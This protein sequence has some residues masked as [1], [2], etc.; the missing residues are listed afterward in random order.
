LLSHYE[1]DLTLV[2]VIVMYGLFAHF[3]LLPSAESLQEF[4]SM[5]N[6]KGGNIMVLGAMSMIFFGTAMRFT[7]WCI[8]QM[9]ENKMTA[10]NAIAMMGVNFITGTCFGGSFASMLKVMS[11][12]NPEVKNGTVTDV[13]TVSAS[14]DSPKAPTS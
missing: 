13:H 14:S 7:Y 5:L 1:L 8:V 3:K 2:V 6:S 4:V 12:E 9:I 11:G 10:D